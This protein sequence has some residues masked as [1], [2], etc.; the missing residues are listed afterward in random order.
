MPEP[1]LGTFLAFATVFQ[2]VIY[3]AYTYKI[4][5][6]PPDWDAWRDRQARIERAQERRAERE[7]QRREDA[8]LLRQLAQ[9]AAALKQLE[10]E[11]AAEKAEMRGQEEK[12][13]KKDI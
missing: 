12:K 5:G 11:R 4:S 9:R 10:E 1:L 7:E 3:G 13:K 2:L 6:G 8:A